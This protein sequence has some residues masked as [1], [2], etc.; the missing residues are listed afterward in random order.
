MVLEDEIAVVLCLRT[1]IL[2]SS[3]N[4]I[5]KMHRMKSWDRFVLGCASLKS[6]P[7]EWSSLTSFPQR[8]V[9]VLCAQFTEYRVR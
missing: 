8:E 6:L 1:G 3:S 7:Q 5:K 2:C 9:Y 4:L